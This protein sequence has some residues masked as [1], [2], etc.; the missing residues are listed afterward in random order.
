MTLDGPLEKLLCDYEE[1][2]CITGYSSGEALLEDMGEGHRDFSLLFFDIFSIR[3]YL[4]GGEVVGS[5]GKLGN[6][7]ARLDGC[8][9]PIRIRDR[10]AMADEYYR[11]FVKHAMTIRGRKV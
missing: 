7:A 3:I 8:V 9:V 1:D 10:K 2:L 6:L 11:F 4:S 5:S